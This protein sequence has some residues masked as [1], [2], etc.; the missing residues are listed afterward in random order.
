M[1]GIIDNKS[2]V[3]DGILTYEG[4]RQMSQNTF[5]V[6]YYTFSDRMLVYRRDDANGHLDPTDK[7][8]FEAFNAPYDQI[9]FEADDSGRLSPFRQHATLET[10]TVT[11]SI[12]SSL[13]WTSFVN[14]KLKARSQIFSSDVDVTGSFTEELIYGQKFAS[15]LEGILTSSLD[16]FKSLCILGT[17]DPIFEDQD[18]ALN[19]EEIQFEINFREDEIAKVNP[20]NVNTIDSL[21]SDEKLN[22]VDNF[23]YL[24]PTVKINDPRIDRTNSLDLRNKNYNLGNYPPWGPLTK[25]TYSGLQEKLKNSNYKKVIFDPTS[26]DNEIIAQIFEINNSEVKKLDV[27]EAKIYSNDSRNVV[28][29]DKKVYY[30]GKVITD[31]TGTDCFVNIFTLV[32][33]NDDEEEQQ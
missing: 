3:L 24:P 4:R 15:M 5:E 17:A 18:F 31:D 20:T 30:V 13:A 14:G 7:L 22:N 28:V 23:L 32:F 27:I 12:T 25:V 8:Y 9:T 2:R 11:G 10:T 29:S 33:G 16:N 26:K 1:S 6:K 19:V 21:F